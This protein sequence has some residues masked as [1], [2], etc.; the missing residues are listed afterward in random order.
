MQ[1]RT[2]S[3]LVW[4]MAL[5]VTA[6]AAQPAAAQYTLNEFAQI[7]IE[8]AGDTQHLKI[9]T[10]DGSIP[11]VG[12]VTADGDGEWVISI[13]YAEAYEYTA[14]I[15]PY[16]ADLKYDSMSGTLHYSFVGP[17]I[18]FGIP[19]DVYMHKGFQKSIKAWTGKYED[20]NM[21]VE[22]VD[23]DVV[24]T[25]N[26]DL[27]GAKKGK[28][29]D[30]LKTLFVASNGIAVWTE[31][32]EKEVEEEFLKKVGKMKLD[33]MSPMILSALTDVYRDVER[34]GVTEGAWDVT[35]EASGFREFIL[36]YGDRV[37]FEYIPG[38]AMFTDEE[39]ASFIPMIEKWIKKKKLKKA[40]TA[41]S[42]KGS[43]P[44]RV[45]VTTT[46][47]MDGKMKGKDFE[48]L[49][50]KYSIDWTTDLWFK[51]IR[52][53]YIALQEPFEK[54][55]PQHL[56][57]RHLQLALGA[58]FTHYAAEVPEGAAGHWKLVYNHFDD[59]EN[60]HYVT[61]YGD[62]FVI[63]YSFPLSD[64]DQAGTTAGL[65]FARQ[66]V[67]GRQAQSA[68]NTEVSLVAGEPGELRLAVTIPVG[69]LTADELSSAYYNFRGTYSSEFH[70]ALMA[71][72]GIE[73]SW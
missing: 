33:Y 47:H 63:T 2:R 66:W 54:T 37:V 44:N 13:N 27:S 4:A 5:C 72:L 26:Y 64:V 25:A 12:A 68:S 46:I 73:E 38:L 51:A 8:A 57:N 43:N 23:S 69:Q 31:H 50:E 61:N 3:P 20:L 7:L 36:N 65:A 41:V 32:S 29:I 17:G 35:G 18:S 1:K 14:I 16:P 67:A 30:R 42:L 55:T 39:R 49:H 28:I 11:T 52:D 9:E 71:Q 58:D 62:R 53:H 34:A 60:W 45:V 21:T 19:E 24:L 59:D 6:F 15:L 22:L 10:E 48:K 56:D 70:T 40:E